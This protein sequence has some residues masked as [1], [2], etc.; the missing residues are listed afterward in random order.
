MISSAA[1]VERAKTDDQFHKH[2]TKRQWQV[3]APESTAHPD[4]GLALPSF[5]ILARRQDFSSG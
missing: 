4:R 2:L 1:E 5:R 3:E